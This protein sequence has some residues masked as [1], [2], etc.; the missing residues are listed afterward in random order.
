MSFGR[1]PRLKRGIG[2][3]GL[4]GEAAGFTN[5][6]AQLVRVVLRGVAAS[7]T[8]LRWCALVCALCHKDTSSTFAN[9]GLFESSK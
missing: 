9:M 1:S 4:L 5:A 7:V 8:V 3:A 2:P 6:L